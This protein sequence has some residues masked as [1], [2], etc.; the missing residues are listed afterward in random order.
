V[1]VQEIYDNKRGPF[2]GINSTICLTR[3][4]LDS[5]SVR[6]QKS[7]LGNDT[8]WGWQ[9]FS[10]ESTQGLGPGDQP[11]GFQRYGADS[12]RS[13]RCRGTFDIAPGV[14]LAVDPLGSSGQVFVPGAGVLTIA[15]GG[16]S[17]GRV[18]AAAR[19]APFKTITKKVTKASVV[20]LSFKLTGA[21]KRTY[22]KKHKLAFSSVVTFTPAGGQATHTTQKIVLRPV[23]TDPNQSALRSKECRRLKKQRKFRKLRCG[24][25]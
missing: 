16:G 23:E 13:L 5:C 12:D 18:T 15:P 3:Y 10:S 1:G 17:N 2:L 21:A 7:F 4:V 14:P 6:Q 22:K 20:T 8:D 11:S 24:G 25:R 19:R 9:C